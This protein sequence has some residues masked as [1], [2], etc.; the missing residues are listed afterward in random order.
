MGWNFRN[1]YFERVLE[2]IMKYSPKYYGD[3]IKEQEMCGCFSVDGRDQKYLYN[4]ISKASMSET[5]WET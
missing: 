4:F 1:N 3:Y 2:Y 5:T